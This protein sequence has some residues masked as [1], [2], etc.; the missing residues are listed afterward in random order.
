LKSKR[1]GAYPA[2][3]VAV[4]A[5]DT[6]AIIKIISCLKSD[7]Y[8]LFFRPHPKEDIEV[9]RKIFSPHNIRL[10][11]ADPFEPITHWLGNVDFLIGPPSTSFYDAVMCGVRPISINALDIRRN[12]FIGE[13]WEDNNRLMDEIDQPETIDE[14]IQILNESQMF[15]PS[16]RM[17][18]IL[19][20]EA[21]FPE[22][23]DSLDKVVSVCY[24]L[25]SK[26]PRNSIFLFCFLFS[27]FFFQILWKIRNGFFNKR[28][29]SSYFALDLK[30]INKINRLTFQ[31]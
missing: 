12:K 16:S 31:S 22:C 10:T 24:S 7:N 15:Y 8:E 4:T 17:N 26:I 5:L 2:E 25:Y 6:G 1:N 19:K 27:K 20:E 14:I 28:T 29:S 11:F 23:K 30:T 13:L 21:D 18:Q 3:N 9:W